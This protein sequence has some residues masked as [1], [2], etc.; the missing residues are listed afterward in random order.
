[1]NI[2]ITGTGYVGLVTGACLSEVGH[3]IT[4][5]DIDEEKIALLNNGISPIF[6]P[7]LEELIQKNSK[8]N[9]LSFTSSSEEAYSQADCIFI[10]VGTPQKHDGSAN[11]EYIEHAAIEIAEHIAK[12]TIVVTKSTVPVGTNEH[13]GR[14]IQERIAPNIKIGIVSNPEFLREGTAIHDTFH[15]DRIVIGADNLE[16]GAKVAKI[17]EPFQLPIVQTDLRSA[18]MIKYASN[19]FLALKISFINEIAN[20]C[21]KVDANIDYV[22]TGVGMDKRIGKQFLHAGIGFGGS[23]FP[24]DIHAL[25]HLASDFDYD[26]KI[27]K[28]VIDVNY[29]QKDRLFHKAKDRFGSL[30]GKKA[31]VLGLTFKPN[32]DDIREAASL[33]LIQDLLAEGVEVT[34]Y[35]PIAMPKVK[36]IFGESITCSD[37]AK[38]ALKGS[39][40]AFIVT[41]WD[42]IKN[43]KLEEVK[44]EMTMPIIFDGRNCFQLEEARKYGIQY[45][46]IGRPQ[47]Y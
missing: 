47:I 43:L 31:T 16:T 36:K 11:L 33:R 29:K 3:H 30:A 22:S 14:I 46:S 26:F 40:V 13:I 1:M 27:L 21:E 18:E 6:E 44:E 37:S 12:D 15:G 24:K 23:C 32:T 8:N 45:Y 10:A 38:N 20:L 28:S 5:Y 34:V 4:C 35:D 39:E 2:T 41:E 7:G 42:E 9:R 19:S 25:N 17:Y